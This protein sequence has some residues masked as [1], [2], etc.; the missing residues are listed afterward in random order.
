M[1][2]VEVLR[3]CDCGGKVILDVE[4]VSPRLL[5]PST[6]SSSVEVCN[7][8]SVSISHVSSVSAKSFHRCANFSNLNGHLCCRLLFK[9]LH[10]LGNCI[11]FSSL[12]I[13]LNFR[14]HPLISQLLVHTSP[15]TTLRSAYFP[16]FLIFF[17]W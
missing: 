3:G 17:F 4:A 1:K 15:P 11:R 16:L 10:F 2:T 12:T 6:C 9:Q 5:L 7:V 14:V 13:N 8:P